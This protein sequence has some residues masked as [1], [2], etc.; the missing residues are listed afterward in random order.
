[1]VGKLNKVASLTDKHDVREDL[2]TYRAFLTLEPH[3]NIDV[4]GGVS[5]SFSVSTGATMPAPLEAVAQEINRI[6]KEWGLV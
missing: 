4:R 6:E 2:I 5:T 1:M 3:M